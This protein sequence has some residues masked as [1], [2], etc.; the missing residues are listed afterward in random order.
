[1][2]DISWILGFIIG[3]FVFQVR[4]IK[5]ILS[6]LGALG[7]MTLILWIL[8]NA[9]NEINPQALLEQIMN[10]VVGGFIGTLFYLIG[11]NI[12]RYERFGK[13]SPRIIIYILLIILILLIFR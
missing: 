1:M 5:G 6:I 2:F 3:L 4:G 10:F 8:N 11:A 12:S 9:K 13:M 7:Y